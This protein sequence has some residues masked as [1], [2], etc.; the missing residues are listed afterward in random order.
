M[1]E[2]YVDMKRSTNEYMDIYIIHEDNTVY[3]YPNCYKNRTRHIIT[4]N[5]NEPYEEITE[6]IWAGSEK[7][8]PLD[9]VRKLLP[10]EV[11]LLLGD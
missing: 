8:I 5:P 4:N 7:N 6:R 3:I 9:E 10:I 2:V 11:W 1:K